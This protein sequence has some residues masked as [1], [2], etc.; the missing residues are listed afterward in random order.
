MVA[1]KIGASLGGEQMAGI[2]TA[3][4]IE[5]AKAALQVNATDEAKQ[6]A[7]SSTGDIVS[8]A[9]DVAGNVAAEG[10]GLAVD[11]AVE[12]VVESIGAIA[13][14]TGEVVVTVIGG[15]FEGLS[16]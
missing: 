1:P 6:Q 4:E 16:S 9:L 7:G 15:I 10:V 14:A 12:T 13:T 2:P 5:A 11:A 8:G 3:E